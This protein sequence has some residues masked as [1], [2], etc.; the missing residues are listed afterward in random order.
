MYYFAY[1]SNMNH[2]QVKERCSNFIFVKRVFLKGYRFV[3]DRNS[4]KRAGPVANILTSRYRTV[5]GGL[6]EINKDNLESLNGHEKNYKIASVNVKDEES[7]SYEAVV[8]L[9]DKQKRGKPN[10]LYRKIVIK[11]AKDYGFPSEYIMKNL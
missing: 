1:G 10:E 5:Y 2:D 11:G 3:Y 9:R 4:K 8:Y 6:Y 7:N